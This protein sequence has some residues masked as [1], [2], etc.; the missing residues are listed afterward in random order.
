MGL[1]ESVGSRRGEPGLPVAMAKPARDSS[2][3][4]VRGRWPL[5]L[6]LAV[7][8]VVLVPAVTHD[9][10]DN[11][12]YGDQTSHVYLALSVAYDSHTL[13]FDRRDAAR[14]SDLKWTAQPFTLFF[15]RYDGG[16][17]ASKPYGYPAYLAP[18][19][20]AL[21]PVTGGAVGNTLL[22]ALLVGGSLLLALRRLDSLTAALSVA[23]FYFAGYIY[24]YAYP[25][26]TELFLAA[27]VLAAY[28]GAYL[29]RETARPVWA[30][31]AVMAMAFGVV[32]KAALLLLFAPL[33]CVIVWELRQRRWVVGVVLAA[34][35]ATI[36]VAIVPYLK[37]SGGD[38]FTPYAGARYQT[39]AT[40]EARTPW[41]GG[42]L[43]VD[44]H[45]SGADEGAIAR[46]AISGKLLDRFESLAYY[47]VGRHTGLLVTA[48]FAL[49]LLVALLV[50]LP[51]SD[52]WA[53]AGLLGIL[54]FIAFYLVVFPKNYYGGGQSLGNR[55]FVQVAPAVL[56][57]ALFAPLGA[58]P[59]RWLALAGIALSALFN[60]P[61]H[62]HPQTAYI[63]MLRTSAPQRLLPIEANQDYTW[64][65]RQLPPPGRQ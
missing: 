35:I 20:A 65:F 5:A 24:M 33:A 29:F 12:P 30:V 48:P 10:R 25:M 64:I 28:G 7:S 41:D 19:V 38:S 45:Q 40:A 11:V 36:A 50:R 13:N 1:P 59:L 3:I 63:Q 32:E 2:R 49:L 8:L 57:T 23:A 43:N 6:L 46:R 21:G 39:F 61:H 55:Y 9:F 54:G 17:A 22:V 15:Q 16:W 53:V 42:Q 26:M 31:L 27:I 4:S 14:W 51:A 58:R 52:R 60:V 56:V 47:A 37:Y 34:G 44:Y 18:F 62:L